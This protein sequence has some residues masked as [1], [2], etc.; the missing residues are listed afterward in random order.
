[1]T[2]IIDTIQAIVRSELR[3]MWSAELGVVEAVYPH[4]DSGDLDNYGCDVLLKNTQLLLKRVPIA[5]GHIGTVATPNVGDLV[6][7]VFE[8][9]DVNQPIVIGRLYNDEDR[10]PLN[11]SDEIIFRLPLAEDDDASILGAVRNHPDQRPPREIVVELPPKITLRIDDG[12]VTAA[13]GTT[14]LRLDQSGTS[15][16]KVTVVAGST[17]ITID[18]DG[19][20]TVESLGSVDFEAAGNLTLTAGGDVSIEA[21]GGLTATAGGRA[22]VEAGAIATLRGGGAAGIEGPMVTVKGMTSFSP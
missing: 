18:Q 19:D 21:G 11:T 7:V 1:M 8:G 6:L 12:T 10:P 15:G 3:S 4:V 2:S 22:T 9:G 14:E 16:G 5:T 13:A 20:V 17:T